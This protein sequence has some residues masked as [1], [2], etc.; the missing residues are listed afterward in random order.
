MGTGPIQQSGRKSGTAAATPSGG[1]KKTKNPRRGGEPAKGGRLALQNWRVR[2][3]LVALIL[4]PTIAGVFL[5][6]L[7]VVA[8]I[9][10]AAD[11]RLVRQNA[12]FVGILG[13]LTQALAMERDISVLFVAQG[14][15]GDTLNEVKE[16]QRRVDKV[17]TE[18]R[19]V[20]AEI[21][22][23]PGQVDRQEIQQVI[24]RIGSLTTLRRAVLETRLLVGD[25]AQ[26][27]SRTIDDFH[28]LNDNISGAVDEELIAS[29]SALAFLAR[30]KEQASRER[31]LLAAALHAGAFDRTGYAQFQAARAQVATELASFRVEASIEQRQF[32]DD[33]L[34]GD[35]TD[36]AAF[37]SSRAI[38]LA[39][40]GLNLRGVV[41]AGTIA[42]NDWFRASTE[43]INRM[44]NVEKVIADEIISR[45]RTLQEDEQANALVV[46][47][48]VVVLLV[49][50]LAVTTLVARSLVRPLRR[51]RTEALEIASNRLPSVVSTLRESGDTG[52]ATEIRPIGVESSDEIGEVARAFDEVHREAI[53]LAGDE[54]KLRSNINAMFVNLSRRTQTLVERQI[55]LIDG[56]EQGEQDGAR[57]ANLFSL[58]HLATRMRRNSENLLV[59]AGQEP[60][61]RWSQPVP[62]VDVV[63]AALSEVENYDRVNLQ[64]QSGIAVAGQ[65]VN[66]VVHL[67]AELVENAISFS[68]RDTRV[69]VSSNRIDGGGLMLG[70]SDAGIG[71]TAEELAHTNER[72]ATPPVVDVSVSRRMG[73]FVVGRLAARHG[74]RVQLR[75]QDVGGLTAMVLLP[76]GLVAHAGSPAPGGFGAGPSAPLVGAGA[77]SASSYGGQPLG[78]PTLFA[79]NTSP[80]AQPTPAWPTPPAPQPAQSGWS[81]GSPSGGSGW[82]SPPSAT[83]RPSGGHSFFDQP[84]GAH[85]FTDRPSGAHSFTDRPSGSHSFTD[86][87]SSGS[88]FADRSSGDSLFSD[89]PSG[90]HS[91][92]GPSGQQDV[93]N[94]GPLPVVR[95]SPM[96]QA[97]EFL[98]IFAAVE[99]DWFRR[100]DRRDGTKP[101]E[102]EPRKEPVRPVVEDAASVGRDTG[103]WRSSPTDVGWQAAQ[104]AQEP[105][106]GGTT[107][108]GLPKRVPRANLVPGTADLSGGSPVP[109]PQPVLS[110]ERVRNRLSSFQQGVRQGRAAVRGGPHEEDAPHGDQS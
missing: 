94:T 32:F 63:R 75:H 103:G 79:G 51:L 89:R 2:S 35:D 13:E 76:E 58:D 11:Y 12:E 10:V 73:L 8:S 102:Q 92:G 90:A 67:I 21:V 64:V 66:D 106:L 23:V 22:N 33:T 71:M 36:R 87:P 4:I 105:T 6:G 61:R 110:P 29:V 45:S 47:G 28:S 26:A 98:P 60:A 19:A 80:P 86:R 55:S 52:V 109:L 7:R 43:S 37:M 24:N 107:S 81:A 50:V 3:R 38:I 54:A 49:A 39:E 56:L 5:G 15:Q 1:T 96:D 65:A 104:A 46:V 42:S 72:L 62:V 48:L 91:F 108:A 44:R 20:A 14:R 16:Q 84:S 95:S 31:A 34:A 9:N 97:E 53:R 30:A 77:G 41:P 74:I 82:S 69:V 99:S 18:V 25:A 100:A 40:Q 93:I 78:S 17:A 88:L 57:L 27:Y 70:I 83:D 68:P 59:L 101:A 85:S